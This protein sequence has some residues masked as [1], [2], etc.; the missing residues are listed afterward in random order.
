MTMQHN[1]DIVRGNFGRN[2][3]EP[4]LQAVAL[5]IDNQRPVFV[6]IAIAAHNGQRRTDCFQIERDRRLANIAQMP[7]LVRFAR[8]IDN[9][10]RQLVMSVG[11]N[12]HAHCFKQCAP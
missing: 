1:I 9:L 7:N 8:K 5:E 6:P 4:K 2:V 3:D 10:L 12:E 11:D